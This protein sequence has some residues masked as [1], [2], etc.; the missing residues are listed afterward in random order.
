MSRSSQNILP[1][2]YCIRLQLGANALNA[3][4]KCI[5]LLII[6]LFQLAIRPCPPTRRTPCDTQNSRLLLVEQYRYHMQ[7]QEKKL[8]RYIVFVNKYGVQLRNAVYLK[9]SCVY[10]FRKNKPTKLRKISMCGRIHFLCSRFN[11]TVD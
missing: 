10:Y 11:V 4:Q 2:V 1:A 6:F 9:N 3:S 7:Y 5:F 8:L